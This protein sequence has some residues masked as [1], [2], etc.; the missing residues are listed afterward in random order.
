MS[1]II[2]HLNDERKKRLDM[3]VF[4]GDLIHDNPEFLPIVKTHFQQLKTPYYTVRGNHDRVTTSLWQ[5]T[6]GYGLNHDI[7]IDKYAFILADTSNEKGEYLCADLEWLNSRLAHYQDKKYIFIFMHIT[8]HKWTENGVECPDL[9]KKIETCPNVAAI[10]HGHD[11]DIDVIK[12][13]N[14]RPYIFDGHYGGS[15]GVNYKGYRIVEIYKDGTLFTYQ[16]NPE[17]MQTVNSQQLKA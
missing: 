6:W 13:S 1:N 10:F 16:H 14:N 15:W 4:N 2:R 5:Q 12:M 7:E 8:P 11:H 17:A 3:C 9:M